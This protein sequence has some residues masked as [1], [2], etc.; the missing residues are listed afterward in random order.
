MAAKHHIEISAEMWEQL[1]AMFDYVDTD[2]NGELDAA[3][4][5]HAIGKH[6]GVE[7]PTEEEVVA[8]IK[9]EL[10]KDGD[11]TWKEVKAA[12]NKWAK[13][14]DYEIPKPMWKGIKEAFK[15]IDADGNGKV[16]ADELK[17]AFPDYHEEEDA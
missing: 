3:E 16:T 8:W 10:E 15:M 1:E 11:I 12:L 14:Q 6:K 17:K 2:G 7:W 13:S 9:G 5:Q 4:V